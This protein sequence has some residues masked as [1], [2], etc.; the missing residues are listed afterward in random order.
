MTNDPQE[1]STLA[2]DAPATRAPVAALAALFLRLGLTAFGGPAAHIAM[3]RA[4]I[5]GRLGWLTEAE[6][7]DLLG[8][9]NLIPG[10]SSTELA[11]YIGR[12][13]GGA[14]GLL[15]AGFCFIL[16][17]ALLVVAFAAVYVRYGYLPQVAAVLYGVKPVVVAVVLQAIVALGRTAVKSRLLAVVGVAAVVAAVCGAPSLPILFAVGALAGTTRWWGIR[18]EL[19]ARPL[20]GLLLASVAFVALPTAVSWLLTPTGDGRPIPSGLLPLFLFFLKVGAT[21]YGSGYVLLAFL[22]DGLVTQYHWLT[23]AQL[24]D[25]V[26][27]GQVTPGPVFT[28]ATFIGYLR[29]GPIGALAATVAI[30]LPSFCFVAVSSRLF[31]RLRSSPVTAGFLDGV[32][33]AALALMIAVTI[34]LARAALVDL[35]TVLLAALSAALLLRWKVNSVWLIGGGALIG[36]LLSLMGY[37]APRLPL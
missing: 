16:P 3:M 15:L 33:V 25:A 10:P 5:V 8:A 17:A 1:E 30:F 18:R 19:R 2:V 12:R 14:V 37:G 29:G 11:I 28:T 4:E 21:L 34:P 22:R 27:V 23:E 26:A 20:V 31:S 32:N 7:L 36:V 35:P 9:A 24:L 13:R 6:F